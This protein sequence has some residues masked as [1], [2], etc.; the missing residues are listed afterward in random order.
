MYCH[1]DP[2]SDQTLQHLHTLLSYFIRSL[3][4]KL[5][6]IDRRRMLAA[7][8]ESFGFV[9]ARYEGSSLNLRHPS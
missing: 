5:T 7:N 4:H 8:F 9:S 3:K 2:A 6:P 1:M